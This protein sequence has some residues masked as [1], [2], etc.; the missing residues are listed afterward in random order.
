MYLTHISGTPTVK[1]RELYFDSLP[2]VVQ[3]HHGYFD[4]WHL[5]IFWIEM[6]LIRLRPISLHNLSI[7]NIDQILTLTAWR[8]HIQ[9]ARF[10]TSWG[11]LT[12]FTPE[13]SF[14]HN[15]TFTERGRQLRHEYKEKENISRR[16]INKYIYD[17]LKFRCQGML[18]L[19]KKKCFVSFGCVIS[20]PLTFDRISQAATQIIYAALSFS[21]VKQL[22]HS[23]K[24]LWWFLSLQI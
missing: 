21:S 5:I 12:A 15:R 3:E 6:G 22:C 19:W 9:L 16:K 4:S 20:V 2:T 1:K 13:T 10:K 23:K 11:K 24:S 14:S 17:F 8:N 18:Q 7:Q